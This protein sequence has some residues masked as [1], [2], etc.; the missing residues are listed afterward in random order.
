MSRFCV[1]RVSLY[2]LR[3]TQ[4]GHLKLALPTV[5]NPTRLWY[6]MSCLCAGEYGRGQSDGHGQ[7]LGS[8]QHAGGRVRKTRRLHRSRPADWTRLP[9]PC[10]ELSSTQ[11]GTQAVPSTQRC[12]YHTRS[13]CLP[14]SPKLKIEL[15]RKRYRGKFSV[16]SIRYWYRSRKLPLEYN[17]QVTRE[18]NCAILGNNAASG[19]NSLLIFRENLSVPSSRV[20]DWTDWLSLNVSLKSSAIC[21]QFACWTDWQLTA[22]RKIFWRR[23]THNWR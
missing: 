16:A 14:E 8:V 1:R 21:R 3:E 9:Q 22:I 6:P 17:V 10:R 13:K 12:E 5:E 23:E 18:E 15:Q 4:F 19:G 7:R 2:W 11:L 20:E